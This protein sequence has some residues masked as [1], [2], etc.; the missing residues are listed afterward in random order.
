MTFTA[1]AETNKPISIPQKVTQNILKRHPNAQDMH[2]SQ[3]N[4]FGKQLLEV[5]FKDEAGQPVLE[6]FNQQGH[7]Y[8]N[9]I[10]IE[11][12]S[13][14]Y[15]QVIAALKA[16]FPKHEIKRAEMIGNPNGVGQEYEIYL[17]ADGIDWKISVTGHGVIQDKQQ[18]KS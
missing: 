2:A 6:L 3:E 13:E 8:T 7:L 12:L 15:P 9:E 1:N 18:I 17:N 11:D 10:I 16:A 4:H 5:S 14:I